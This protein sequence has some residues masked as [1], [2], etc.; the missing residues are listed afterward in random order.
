MTISL[1]RLVEKDK[2]IHK[3]VQKIN[4]Y[5]FIYFQ[6]VPKTLRKKSNVY[7]L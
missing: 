1:K 4:K 3:N 2:F 6:I 7:I 5:I